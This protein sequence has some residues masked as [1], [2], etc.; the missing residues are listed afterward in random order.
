[1]LFFKAHTYK[2]KVFKSVLTLVLMYILVNLY[3]N[4][5]NLFLMLSDGFEVLIGLSLA[6]IAHN[7]YKIS[8]NNLFTVLA[9]CFGFISLVVLSGICLNFATFKTL[10]TNSYT[11]I[12]LFG[13][14]LSVTSLL[15][16][17]Y[18]H[19]KV[20]N[21][22]LIFSLYSC[23]VVI[24][25]L[26]LFVLNLFP[27]LS[28]TAYGFVS[29]NM[30]VNFSLAIYA[31]FSLYVLLK[32]PKSL[33]LNH[34]RS[35][36]SLCYSFILCSLLFSFY[37]YF[38]HILRF[39]THLIPLI[40]IYILY[41]I[42]IES[43]LLHPYNSLFN[44]LS[45]SKNRYKSLVQSLTDSVLIRDGAK[46]IFAN[47]TAL[48][49]F[50]CNEPSDLMGKSLFEFVCS[51]QATFLNYD[52]QNSKYFLDI[53]LKTIHNRSFNA[54]I[55]E[56][57]I[58]F[59]DKPCTLTV[60]K[61]LSEQ[62]KYRKLNEKLNDQI[63][64]EK[65][66]TNFFANLSH[67]LKTP[68]HVIYSALQVCDIHIKNSNVTKIKKYNKIIKQNCF[69]LIRICN[70]LLDITKLDT[71]SFNPSIKCLNIVTIIER[72]VSS[73]DLYVINKNMNITFDTDLEDAFC[74]CDKVL[75]ERIILNLISNSLKYGE[76]NGS[77]F[78]DIY[79]DDS[80]MKIVFKDDGPGIAKQKCQ[81]VFDRFTQLDKSF[82]RKCEGSGIGLSLVKSLIELQNGTISL[83]SSTG[84]GC[85]FVISLPRVTLLPLEEIAITNDCYE[86]SNDIMERINIEFSDIYF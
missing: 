18:F 61:N 60:I 79:C 26:I 76:S 16:A 31:L 36:L 78:I 62:Q 30:F 38:N 6:V 53:N 43:V 27:N 2:L 58:I 46:I 44:D 70:N 49:L 55:S 77:I 40:K 4:N 28:D 5:M 23:L 72:I 54:E 7:T 15:L 73:I 81:D 8:K 1:M 84:T 85:E 32:N 45:K 71:N 25:S 14:F 86:E 42:T 29:I 35:L 12:Q 34:R 65:L 75:I 17:Y 22:K 66:R 56:I 47:C 24:F 11:Y 13:Q 57:D 9:I 50:E 64:E 69:R 10:D 48:K 82:T 51:D 39:I 3:T 74:L 63:A 68:V 83:K 19:D 41:T 59:D 52:T 67:E 80:T 33:S 21:F 37:L 20:V